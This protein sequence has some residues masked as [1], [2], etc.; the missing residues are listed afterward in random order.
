MSEVETNRTDERI[1]SATHFGVRPGDYTLGSLQ[2]RAAAR[3]LLTQRRAEPG[4]RIRFVVSGVGQP[5]NL[6]VST[7]T[8]R[9]G[10]NGLLTEI[11]MLHGTSADLTGPEMDAFVERWPISEYIG[12]FA[13][14]TKVTSPFGV[15]PRSE[16]SCD[17]E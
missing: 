3:L 15:T 10:A 8:R 1:P 13:T 2:S 4:N 12:G 5:L 17:G 9:R 7:C 14:S 6:A 11:V 16:R